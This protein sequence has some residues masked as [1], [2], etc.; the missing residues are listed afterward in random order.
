MTCCSSFYKNWYSKYTN[1][2]CSILS[3]S[4]IHGNFRSL[5]YVLDGFETFHSETLPAYLT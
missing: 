4:E 1:N 2:E 3:Y 5:I